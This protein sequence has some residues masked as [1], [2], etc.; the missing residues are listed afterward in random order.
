MAVTSDELRNAGASAELAAI[1]SRELRRGDLTR[2]PM[3]VVAVG[4][5]LAFLGWLAVTVTDMRGE[6]RANQAQTEARIDALAADV[7]EIRKLLLEGQK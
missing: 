2:H 3:A 7:S 4:A 1:L 5:F 6:M